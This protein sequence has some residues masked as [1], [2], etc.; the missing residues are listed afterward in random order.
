MKHS[1]LRSAIQDPAILQ[2]FQAWF[3]AKKFQGIPSKALASVTESV[4]RAFARSHE[5][6]DLGPLPKYD[7]SHLSQG[8]PDPV[9]GPVADPVPSPPGA[10]G[11][12]RH[13]KSCNRCGTSIPAF[14]GSAAQC[15]AC[16]LAA[17]TAAAT[18][19]PEP[20]LSQGTAAETDPLIAML[21]ARLKAAGLVAD[22]VPPQDPGVSLGTIE[23]LIAQ[24]TRAAIEAM[25]ADGTLVRRQVH[26]IV[27]NGT[28]TA[29]IEGYLPSWFARLY[30]LAQCR[31]NALLVGPAGSG[32]TTGV[33]KLA[34][35]LQ[36]PFY[37]VSLSA[38]VDEGVLQGWLLPVEVGG[39]FVYAPSTVVQAYEHGGVVLLDEL[40]AADANMLIILSAVLDNGQWSIPMRHQQP[41]LVRHKDF[42]VVAA[43]NTFGHGASRQFV[44]AQQ[45][46]ERTLSRFRMGQIL[47]DYDA[48]LERNLFDA[49][50][51]EMG[52]RIRNRCRAIPDFG[53][54]VSTR[55]IESAHLKLQAFTVDEVW[56]EF[57]TDWSADELQRVHVV[58]DHD[59]YQAVCA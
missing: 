37:R 41:D 39:Q 35:A 24:R 7:K 17:V 23:A 50:V 15:N 29:A 49:A 28:E 36:L 48:D 21:A 20:V 57:F 44:G 54:D 32:K 31:I 19:A 33:A 51:V 52:H 3:V 8:F 46:D 59:V 55:D 30:K 10:T 9:A 40:D 34:Q 22:P 11:Q 47:C 38:G 1:T 43:A 18:P 13:I 53:R 56:Y 12:P 45:L 14:T 6:S 58:L 2:A 42:I 25:L 4:W 26:S 27:C 5:A 16:H